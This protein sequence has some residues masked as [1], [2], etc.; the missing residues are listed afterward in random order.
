MKYNIRSFLAIPQEISVRKYFGVPEEFKLDC[1]RK[2][3]A[4]HDLYKKV[5]LPF[6]GCYFLTNAVVEHGIIAILSGGLL[7]LLVAA[8][9]IEEK[10]P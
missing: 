7:V 5:A 10:M 3:R 8:W 1:L 2:S 4:A 6:H 9:L